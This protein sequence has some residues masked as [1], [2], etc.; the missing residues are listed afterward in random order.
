MVLVR[1]EELLIF[2]GL[3]PK[4]HR[5]KSG[6]HILLSWRIMRSAAAHWQDRLGEGMFS[7]AWRLWGP[8]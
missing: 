2:S 4:A 1:V 6:H 7:K 5:I 3:Y 8:A